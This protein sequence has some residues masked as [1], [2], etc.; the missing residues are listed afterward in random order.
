MRSGVILAGGRSTRMGIDKC[1]LLF[2]GKPLIYWPYILIKEIVDV[3]IISV[4]K[5]KDTGPLMRLLGDDVKFV[6]DEKPNMGPL[7]GI[8]SSFKEAK[9]E[10][11]AVIPCDSPLV[12]EDLYTRLFEVAKGHDG[13]V[14]KVRSFYEPL[15]AVYKRSAMINAIEKV[16][17]GG[18]LRP[19][20]TYEF[21]EVVPLDEDEIKKFDPELHSFF[22]INSFSDIASA[23]GIFI[24]SRKNRKQ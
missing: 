22:N 11:V 7:S 6:E 9:G 13:A 23:S 21:M 1:T 2:Q 16:F 12:H 8:H 10:F 3:I 15:H 20:A 4:A 18:E 5:G 17:A 24:S 19:K 14:P